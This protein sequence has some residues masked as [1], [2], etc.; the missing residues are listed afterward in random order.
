M[1]S[2]IRI[3]EAEVIDAVREAA[4]MPDAPPGALTAAQMAKNL[5]LSRDG[6]K[7][8]LAKLRDSGR[9]EVYRIRQT[10]T[11]GRAQ[12]VPAYRVKPLKQRKR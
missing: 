1:A 5:G 8:A 12:L 6:V 9:L 7:R 2:M 3:T 11:T 4:V 10:D